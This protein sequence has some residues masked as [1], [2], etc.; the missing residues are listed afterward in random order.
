MSR[1][2]RLTGAL[3]LLALAA[4]LEAQTTERF[5]QIVRLAQDGLVD[6][7]R[8]EMQRVLGEFPPSDPIFP[9][10]LYTSAIVA[11][12]DTERRFA[13]RRVIIEYSRS[14]WADDALLLLAQLEYADAN[15]DG[16]VAQI[17][18]LIDDYPL[19]PL[20]AVGAF[21]G[22]RAAGDLGNGALACQWAVVGLGAVKDDVELR[23]QL[24]F[25]RLRC[26]GLLAQAA[27]SAA[28]PADR[29]TPSPAPPPS[30]PPPPPATPPGR[31]APGIY[32]QVG[33]LDTPAAA[34]EAAAPLR[35]AGLPVVIVREGPYHKVRVG[36]Y[37]KRTQANEALARI[38]RLVRTQPFIVTLR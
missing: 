23:T 2:I 3:A 9:E 4:P 21:W 31:P 5:V 19:S 1:S 10:A 33:A 11:E 27:D 6:S 32:V 20:R 13:L 38:R 7:A 34:E 16:T 12:S 28:Q 26:E 35:E 30:P 24:D 18:K 22:A 8:A 25:Q 36:P 37:A 29:N 17:T 15:P 14:Q